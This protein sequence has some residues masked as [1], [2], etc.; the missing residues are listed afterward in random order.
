MN[1]LFP[2]QTTPFDARPIELMISLCPT[3]ARHP[4]PA[5]TDAIT[6]LL[7]SSRVAV[8]IGKSTVGRS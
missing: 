6:S 2:S 4:C 7:S 3:I 8:S 5:S 1:M